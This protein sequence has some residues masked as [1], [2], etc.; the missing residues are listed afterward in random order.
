MNRLLQ[1]LIIFSII[2]LIVLALCFE[3]YR[4]FDANIAPDSGQ[5]LANKGQFFGVIS[6]LFAGLAFAGVCATIPLL[7]GQ[8]KAAREQVEVSQ[9]QAK[10][11]DEAVRVSAQQ[12]LF[13]SLSQRVGEVISDL[14]IS[15]MPRNSAFLKDVEPG[16]PRIISQSDSD[17][18]FLELMARL[19]NGQYGVPVNQRF[20]RQALFRAL[21]K[22]FASSS[23]DAL[24]AQIHDQAAWMIILNLWPK[25][26]A[27]R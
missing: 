10:I 23:D 6:S 24:N 16:M 8:A 5:V 3:A 18:K 21:K 25:R 17:S 13:L 11:A 26:M 4:Y 7:S 22:L 27:K 15:R 12:A 1:S 19:L 20:R 9:H 2:F 14:E